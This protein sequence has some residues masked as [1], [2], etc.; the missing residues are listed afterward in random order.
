MA[1]SFQLLGQIY[2]LALS[3]N[4]CNQFQNESFATVHFQVQGAPQLGY[5]KTTRL[6]AFLQNSH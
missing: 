5:T 4:R 6:Q 2:A 1:Q 3:I